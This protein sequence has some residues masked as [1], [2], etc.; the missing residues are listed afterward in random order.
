VYGIQ[1]LIFAG[2]A[3]GSAVTWLVV[4]FLLLLGNMGWLNHCVIT[5]LGE[6]ELNV[7]STQA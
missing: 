4:C 2:Q 3:S 7:V 5:Y 6:G 1:A